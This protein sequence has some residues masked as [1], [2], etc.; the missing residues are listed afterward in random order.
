[1]I[2]ANELRIGNLL[3]F[4]DNSAIEVRGIHPSGKY[5]HDGKQW[6]E[7]FRCNHIPITEEWLLNFGFELPILGSSIYK[8]GLGSFSIQHFG[9]K[10]GFFEMRNHKKI[11]LVHQLQ[12]LYFA[13]KGTELTP[14]A[15]E[16]I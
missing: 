2:Q 9:D 1:M 15:A 3:L 13:L 14:K 8:L 5:I 7:I 6:I 4:E 10:I 11:D 12:N 16:I